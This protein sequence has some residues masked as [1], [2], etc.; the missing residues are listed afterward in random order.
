[1]TAM[2]GMMA[3]VPVLFASAGYVLVSARGSSECTNPPD[4]GHI[5][6]LRISAMLSS[7]EVA[8][9]A[10]ASEGDLIARRIDILGGAHMTPRLADKCLLRMVIG[11]PQF[12]S[13]PS[14]EFVRMHRSAHQS[15]ID[16]IIGRRGDTI[17]MKPPSAS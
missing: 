9:D 7:F 15:H 14:D 8:A 5:A 6:I 3:M 16:N 13:P 10:G 4:C 17:V 11:R 1:M 2:F 12:S